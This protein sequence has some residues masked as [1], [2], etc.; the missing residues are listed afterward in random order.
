[1][2]LCGVLFLVYNAN[3]REIGS[4][5]TQPSKFAARELLLRGT[6]ALNHVVGATPEYAER[7][8]FIN[9]ADGRYRSIYSPVPSLAAAAITWPL[10]KIGLIDI[11]APAAPALMAKLTASLLISLSAVL[12][13]LAARAYA[14]RGQALL[15]AFG[16]GL[17]TGFWSTA[18]QTLWQTETSTLGLTIAV[19]AFAKPG[20]HLT[21]RRAIAI[22]IGLGLAVITRPQLAPAVIAILAGTWLRTSVRNAII[23]SAIIAVFAAV[24][25]TQNLRWFGHALGALPLIQAYN[26]SVH[27]SGASFRLSPEGWLGLLVSPSRGLLVFSPI[28]LVAAWGLRPA[29]KEGWRAPAVWCLIAAAAQYA[30]YATYSVWWGGHT[31]GPRYMLDVLPLLVPAAAVGVARLSSNPLMRS[32]GALG[33]AWWVLVAATGAFCY[34]ADQWNVV[35]N[36]IDRNHARL[37]SWTDTQIGRCWHTGLSPQNFTLFDR[38]SVRRSTT[39]H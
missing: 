9:A 4:F 26:A 17:G 10:W 30:L 8:G 35:P 2:V 21:L 15:V 3:G 16:L 22:G 24:L 25:A 11:R 18:S 38:L 27:K 31:Y 36:D 32:A 5:D 34:P 39:P 13:F 37:W 19:L 14:S 6:L 33:L 28:A 23:T 29:I 20:G 1:M 12:A 7:W